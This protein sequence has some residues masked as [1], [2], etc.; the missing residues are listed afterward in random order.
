MTPTDLLSRLQ[1]IA[2]ET[3]ESTDKDSILIG[4]I[5]YTILAAEKSGNLEM[6]AAL[7]FHFSEEQLKI[8]QALKN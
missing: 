2:E 7:A 4:A 6:L 3:K 5:I 1:S 8:I